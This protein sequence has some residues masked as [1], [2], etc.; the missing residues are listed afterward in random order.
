MEP[1]SPLTH[2]TQERELI[3][4]NRRRKRVE[5]KARN[6]AKLNAPAATLPPNSSSS[7][8]RDP[9][10]EEARLAHCA[11]KKRQTKRKLQ[12]LHSEVEAIVNMVRIE[13][14]THSKRIPLPSPKTVLDW[15]EMPASLSPVFDNNT[16]TE[17][18]LRKRQ[19]CESFL[20]IL[21]PLVDSLRKTIT[22]RRLRVADFGCGTGNS[23]LPLAHALRESCDFVLFDRYEKPIQIAEARVLEAK[24]ANVT[25]KTQRIEHVTD[26]T[27]DICLAF[28]VCGGASDYVIQKSLDDKSAFIVCSCCIGKLKHLSRE[29]CFPRSKWLEEKKIS[30]DQYLNLLA[31]V[32]DHCNNDFARAK[33]L[34]ELDRLAHASELGC[35]TF[36]TNIHPLSASPKND[37]IVALPPSWSTIDF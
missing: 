28:H 18:G 21:E 2:M 20:R 12:R 11:H 23:S 7:A 32:A 14:Q 6:G 5:A 9:Q 25:C 27:F 8:E 16:P 3:L 4:A 13:E 34:I 22:T 24:L 33:L 1:S 29:I 35:Q 30:S 17:R 37:I 26:E 36:H 31:K 15:S 19:Q 10:T